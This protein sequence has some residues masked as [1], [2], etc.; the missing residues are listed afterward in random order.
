MCSIK[1]TET[2]Q[3]HG[4]AAPQRAGEGPPAGRFAWPLSENSPATCWSLCHSLLS[5]QDQVSVV[6]TNAIKPIV[7]PKE[8][9]YFAVSKFLSKLGKQKGKCSELDRSF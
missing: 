1:S 6:N 2:S 4:P 5:P 8:E 7:Y 9:K 3:D